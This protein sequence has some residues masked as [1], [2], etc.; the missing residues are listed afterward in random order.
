MELEFDF[1]VCGNNDL[2]IVGYNLEFGGSFFE[3]LFEELTNIFTPGDYIL[4]ETDMG[5]QFGYIF[6]KKLLCFDNIEDFI[7]VKNLYKNK[8]L[9]SEELECVLNKKKIK[10]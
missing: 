5:S 10:I 1:K 9:L 6:D 7:E 8:K 4:F 3:Y 2:I